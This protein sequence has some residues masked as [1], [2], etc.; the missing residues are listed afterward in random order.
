[1]AR[2]EK[3]SGQLQMGGSKKQQTWQEVNTSNIKPLIFGYFLCAPRSLGGG[4]RRFLCFDSAKVWFIGAIGGKV[5]LYR[6]FG[7]SPELLLHTKWL[8]NRTFTIFELFSVIPALWLPNR[9]V[10]GITCLGKKC[11]QRISESLTELL[12]ELY[13]VVWVEELPNR[14]SFGIDSV[15]F[16]CAMVF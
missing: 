14:N 12:W 1:M 10:S 4:G 6:S 16:L 9:I 8:P 15:I 11:E 7:E 3:S 2:L 13:S 5:G